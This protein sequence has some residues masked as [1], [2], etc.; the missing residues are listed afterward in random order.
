MD[1]S[2]GSQTAEMFD[3]YV[4]L[5]HAGVEVLTESDLYQHLHRA[6]EKGLS[7]TIHAIGDKANSKT[8]NALSRVKEISEKRGLRHR[9]EHAQILNHHDIARFAALNVIASMQPLHIA[10]D[11]KIS[12]TYLGDRSMLAYPIKSLLQAGCRV[13]FGSDLP[14]ANPDPIKGILS[15]YSRR[16]NLDKNEPIW[17]EEQ[18]ISISQALAAYTREA[19]FSSYEESTKGTLSP[20]KL[21]DF[22]VISTDL[23]K[24]D[25]EVLRDAEVQM[26][27]LDGKV[28]YNKKGE[29]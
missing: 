7:A 1:G 14:V 25:E 20:G 19:A 23:E 16:Y 24:A 11:V 5:D 9:I 10:D 6:A 2:L 15:A 28:I 13:V 29:I 27:V 8:L 21:A 12:D 4:G 18:C 3:N 22:F 26:T 17:H